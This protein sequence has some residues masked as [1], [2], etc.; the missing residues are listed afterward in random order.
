MFQGVIHSFG[1]L[2]GIL[3]GWISVSLLTCIVL[4]KV[5]QNINDCYVISTNTIQIPMTNKG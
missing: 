4:A 5:E 2:R 3:Q 1:K